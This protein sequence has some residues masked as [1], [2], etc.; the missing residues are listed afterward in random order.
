MA[1]DK[2]ILVMD[3]FPFQK[4]VKDRI[5]E[6]ARAAISPGV[7]GD[8]YLLTDGANVNKIAYISVAD[9]VPTWVYL[10]PTEG[11]VMWVEDEDEY[12]KFDG[13]TWSIYI[14]EKGDQGD[15][16]AKGDQGDQGAKGDQGNQGANGVNLTKWI[17]L[18]ATTDFSTTAASTSTIT[19]NSDKT[20]SIKT[21]MAIKFKLSGSY[22]YA[23]CTAITT[24]LL[25]IAGAPLT[26]GAGDLQELYYSDNPNSIDVVAISINGSFADAADTALLASDLNMY[27]KWTKSIAYLVMISHI[28]KTQDTGANQSRVNCDINGANSVSTANTNAGQ[29]VSTSW[30]NTV[31]DINTTNYDINYGESIEIRTDANGSNDDAK[32]LTVLLTFV[33]A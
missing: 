21:G 33:F 4:N 23:I 32:D 18:V 5:T 2:R 26:T 15:Q 8:R 19:M 13:S 14:G 27:L 24:N 1:T 20:G 25:T 16:G 12:Y 31:V 29:S 30:V 28:V 17:Q 11:Y 9:T 22:Y 7:R 3:E 10:T 6:A